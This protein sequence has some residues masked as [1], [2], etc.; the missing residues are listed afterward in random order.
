[1]IP[2]YVLAG[3]F[4]LF[5]GLGLAGLVYFAG[6]H[7][8]LQAAVAVMLLVAATAHWGKKRRDLIAMVPAVFPRPDLL[9]T[10]T[11]LLE[12]AGAVGLLLPATSRWA[13]IG[14]AILLIALFPANVRAAQESL[15]LGG[16]AVPKLPVRAALQVIFIAAVLAAG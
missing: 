3:A 4:L 5:R 14:L 7:S 2:L 12:I 16:R 8:S 1:M 11:G 10:A 13:S 6:W 15:T 9:V